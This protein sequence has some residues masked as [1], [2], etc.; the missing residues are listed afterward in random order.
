[1]KLTLHSQHFQ[2]LRK[3]SE[4]EFGKLGSASPAPAAKGTP[5][6][7]KAT[8]GVTPSKSGGKRKAKSDVEEDDD[9]DDSVSPTKKQRGMA[10][11]KKIKVEEG[12]DEDEP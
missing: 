11:E 9:E 6:N 3:E 7:P 4:A 5:R 8:N 1:M 2:K 10:K 12:E